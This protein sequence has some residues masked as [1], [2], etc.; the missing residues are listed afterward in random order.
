MAGNVSSFAKGPST[1]RRYGL[2]VNVRQSDLSGVDH[3]KLRHRHE[4]FEFGEPILDESQLCCAFSSS[5]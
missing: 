1:D 2:V 4:A 3:E 5:R